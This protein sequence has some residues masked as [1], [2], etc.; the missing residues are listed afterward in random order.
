MGHRVVG[1]DGEVVGLVGVVLGIGIEGADADLVFGSQ[2]GDL[3]GLAGLGIDAAVERGGAE[4]RQF[5]EGLDPGALR[6][7]AV[8]ADEVVLEA[9]SNGA[10]LRRC[11]GMGDDAVCGRREGRARMRLGAVA[12]AGWL[13]AGWLQ[14]GWLQAGWLQADW[15]QAGWLQADWLQ[16][17]WLQ[18]GPY[19]AR[20]PI[21]AHLA[22]LALHLALALDL[23][24]LAAAPRRR[25]AKLL[26]SA[27]G[28]AGPA[29]RCARFS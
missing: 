23:G 4:G 6:R 16:A 25:R 1:V 2:V 22:Y 9:A 29:W 13:Q 14:A 11:C 26:W 15:L 8:G 10:D 19:W 12:A 27:G 5:A 18:A 20:G 3:D 21:P 17:D 28:P 7:G 24:C